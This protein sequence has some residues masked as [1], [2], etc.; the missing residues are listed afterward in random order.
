[1]FETSLHLISIRNLIALVLIFT[2]DPI[3]TK[4]QY[5]VDTLDIVREDRI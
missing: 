5:V 3:E 1:M 2:L 4:K